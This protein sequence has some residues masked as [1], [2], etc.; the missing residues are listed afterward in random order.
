MVQ[1]G[2]VYRYFI[3]ASR[4]CPMLMNEGGSDIIEG[5][6]ADPGTHVDV[7]KYSDKILQVIEGHISL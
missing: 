4:Y 3:S 6:V 5:L 2:G 1:A 7:K